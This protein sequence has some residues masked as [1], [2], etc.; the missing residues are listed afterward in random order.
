LRADGRKKA[1]N[2]KSVNINNTYDQPM[3][4]HFMPV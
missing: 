4:E 1:E 3:D 2:S